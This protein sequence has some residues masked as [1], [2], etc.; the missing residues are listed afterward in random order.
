[1]DIYAQ[2]RSLLQTEYDHGATDQ[3]IADRLGCSHQQVNRL[4][5]GQRSFHKMRL[6]TLLQLFPNLSIALDGV[7]IH[8]RAATINGNGNIIVCRDANGNNISLPATVCSGEIEHFRSGLI[9]ELID[10]EIETAAKDTVL[11]TVRNFRRQM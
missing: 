6:E 4:R 10:L 1:M 7:P 5:N 11:R 2:L 9:M 8:G 3:E